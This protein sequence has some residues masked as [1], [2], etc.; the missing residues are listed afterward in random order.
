MSEVIIPDID[1]EVLN[2]LQTRAN[3]HGHSLQM[4]LKRIL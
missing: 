2:R 1:D 3:H 4:E